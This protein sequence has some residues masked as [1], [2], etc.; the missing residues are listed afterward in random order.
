VDSY[1]AIAERVLEEARMPL[2]PSEILRRA[3]LADAVPPQLYGR[4]QH[5][6][7][8]ARLSEDILLKRERSAFFRT[9]PGHY[10]LARVPN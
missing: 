9:D 10:L 7:L 5:K 2:V 3:Y 4:T 8:Q 1:L 6:T